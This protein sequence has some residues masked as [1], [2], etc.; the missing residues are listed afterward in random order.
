MSK[1]GARIDSGGIQEE[2]TAPQIRKQVLVIRMST[3]GP[4]AVEAGFAKVVGVESKG[5]LQ[6]LEETLNEKKQL[7]KTWPYGDGRAAEKV[8]RI[9]EVQSESLAKEIH[10]N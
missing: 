2:D 9:I 4:E 10:V 7:P 3:E 1:T 6:S 8:V 5:V